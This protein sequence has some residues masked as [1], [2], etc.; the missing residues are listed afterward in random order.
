MQRRRTRV[1][2]A[3]V[4]M[5]T[6]RSARP[7]RT[8]GPAKCAAF[9]ARLARAR[10]RAAGRRVG[11]HRHGGAAAARDEL[12]RSTPSRASRC[13]LPRNAWSTRWRSC[14][15]GYFETVGMTIVRGRGFTDGR[16]RGGAA[17]R[18]HQRDVRAHRM[19]RVR[20][21]SA[22]ASAPGDDTSQAP[23]MTVVGV[24]RDAHRS[25]VTRAIRPEIYHVARCRS[26]PRTQTLVGANDWRSSPRSC[27]PCA[28]RCRR[29]IRSCRC[30]TS[31]HS[32][33]SWRS[34]SS[35]SRFQAVLL[36]RICR[37]SRCCSRRSAFTASP[38]T[39]S[40][41]ARR[42]SASAWRW[43]PARGDVLRL[44]A[45]R[46][47]CGRRLPAS[48]I[49]AGRSLAAQPLRC[50]V[51]SVRRQRDR[52]GDVRAASCALLLVAAASRAGFP[53][54]ARRASIRS[55]PCGRNKVPADVRL[56][57]RHVP[58]V[59]HVPQCAHHVPKVLLC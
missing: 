9:F 31:R 15:P 33:A 18:R 22:G 2:P 17:R 26:T 48:A 14:R 19:A 23:W 57:C 7:A 42:K 51:C 47:I 27:R 13:L 36:A 58:H 30:S 3:N 8:P 52:S 4:A 37:R 25:D 34:R 1:Q 54:V 50:R 53:R 11:G 46:S 29:S 5:M 10:A 39:P 59:P 32:N 16:S 41:S 38:R 55:S 56:M 49:G 24:I 40:A 45:A 44:H 20:T 12:G 28:A 35:Q 21:R 43:V 6:V